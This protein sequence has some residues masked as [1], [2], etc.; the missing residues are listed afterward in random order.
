MK[1]QRAGRELDR[2]GNG[3]KISEM[4]EIGGGGKGAG[5]SKKD[6]GRSR[7]VRCARCLGER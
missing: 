5:S 2:G 7:P 6:E 1:I 3:S 4:G